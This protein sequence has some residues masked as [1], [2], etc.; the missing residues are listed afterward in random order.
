MAVTSPRPGTALLSGRAALVTG[1]SRGIGA[2]IA[3][4]LGRHGAAVAVNYHSNQA[5][6]EAV[7][8]DVTASGSRA[9]ALR[10]DAT[11]DAGVAALV[12]AATAELG[13]IDVLVCNAVG[14]TTGMNRLDG[15]LLD[16]GDAV[17]R[18]VDQQ[19]TATLAAC[20]QVVPGMRRR[21]GGSIVLIGA[22][23]T[24]QSHVMAQLAEIGVAK[25]AQDAL[26][27]YL[28][29]ELGA[30][31][32]RVNVVAPG[33]VPT[34]ANAGAHRP[35]VLDRIAAMTPLGRVSTTRDVA[36][37]VLALASDLTGQMTGAVLALDGGLTM[38]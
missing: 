22:S 11:D 7:V 30:D 36:D 34:D 14:D 28:A 1:G 13:D 8:A 10:G 32:I 24:R 25:A 5:A 9:V 23:L 38:A 37:T 17:R 12:T 6:A 19:L 16:S 27:R 3:R 29:A 2:E 35:A 4:T 21:G 15:S 20:R 31:G 33:M 18:R 26:A